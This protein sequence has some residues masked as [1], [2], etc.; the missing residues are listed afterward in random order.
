MTLSVKGAPLEKVFKEIQKQ[1]GFYFIYTKE[2]LRDARTVSLQVK[3]AALTEVLGTCFKEQPLSYTIEENHV[4]IK[5]KS[6]SK[7][8]AESKAGLPAPEVKGKV[9][10]ESG[11]PL[12]GISVVVKE[13][14]KGTSTDGNGFFTFKDVGENATLVF[15]GISVETLE[16]PLK[17]RQYVEVALKSRVTALGNVS[18]EVN[19][20]YQ[21]LP[22]ERATGSFTKIDREQFNQQVTADVLSRL[23]AIGNGVSFGK[24]SYT[25]NGQMHIRGLS[26][27]NGPQN[28]LIVVDDFPYEGNLS[29]LNPN[30]V[31][32]ITILKDA[33]AASIWGARAANGVVVITTKKSRYNQRITVEVNANLKL[34]N[35]PDLNYIPTMSSSDFIDVEQYLFNKGYRFFPTQ[36]VQAGPHSPRCMK[37]CSG[38]KEV[39]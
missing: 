17:G 7:I 8:I 25:S 28:P 19:T 33:A 6:E 21:Q 14:G 5:R 12:E 3:D 22:K 2:D 31:E 37:S 10:N 23:E 4:I 24:K 36:P 38:K 32:S 16:L 13:T 18:V 26:T 11:E 20:G 35:K 39:S 27:I 15:S 1:T 34:I 30:D 9:V 29:N